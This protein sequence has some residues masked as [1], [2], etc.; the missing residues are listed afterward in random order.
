MAK[1]SAAAVEVQVQAG[2]ASGSPED[3]GFTAFPRASVPGGSLFR[4]ASARLRARWASGRGKRGGGGGGA[5][6][7]AERACKR[8][9]ARPPPTHCHPHTARSIYG[10]DQDDLVY[11]SDHHLDRPGSAAGDAD[12]K[13]AQDCTRGLRRRLLPQRWHEVRRAGCGW[14]RAGTQR[15]RRAQHAASLACPRPALCSTAPRLGA[16]AHP[17]T[18]PMLG[19]LSCSR[20]GGC[21]TSPCC[22]TAPCWR[23]P[24]SWC[25]HPTWPYWP[26][27]GAWAGGRMVS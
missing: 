2:P 19:P 4:R 6:W 1:Q 17:P 22:T 13:A 3:A 9:P 26:P 25:L 7:A 10:R 27:V 14:A 18:P 15:G 24:A 20:C 21:W 23:W 12:A 8:F 16:C 5:R 11:G